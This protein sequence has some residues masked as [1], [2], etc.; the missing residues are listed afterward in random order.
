MFRAP[1]FTGARLGIH[2][3]LRGIPRRPRPGE[4]PTM[5]RC[6]FGALIAS[7]LLA[8]VS[9][10]AQANDH[11]LM[12]TEILEVITAESDAD[13]DFGDIIPGT[14]NG[15]VVMTP[16]ATATCATSGGIVRT[17]PCL[18]ARFEGT[19]PIVYLLRVTKPAGNQI[20][21]V[22][23][24]GATMRLHDF[25][26]AKGTPGMMGGTATNPQYLVLGGSFIIYVGGTLDVA[27]NQRPGIYNGTFELSFN[28]E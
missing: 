12:R 21:L 10:L 2:G 6:A 28:Y 26:F 25:T 18:A 9:A 14:S 8:P 16:A 24:A 13:M 1:T 11:A 23:P 22:G 3:M 20:D 7:L 15:T 4:R 17:G 5:R 19:L 27:S